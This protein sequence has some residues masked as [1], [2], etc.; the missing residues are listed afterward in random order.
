MASLTVANWNLQLTNLPISVPSRKLCI[1]ELTLEQNGPPTQDYPVSNASGE[2]S[3]EKPT[4]QPILEKT[5]LQYALPTN[6]HYSAIY[7]IFSQY[8]RASWENS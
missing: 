4:E 1:T 8:R 6:E 3:V 5:V 2:D 7:G